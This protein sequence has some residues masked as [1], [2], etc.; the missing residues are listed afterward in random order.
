MT[1][2]LYLTVVISVITVVSVST[3]IFSYRVKRDEY[4]SVLK[5][6]ISVEK[7]KESEKRIQDFFLEY[8]IGQEDPITEVAKVLNVLQGESEEGLGEQAYI[9]SHED[10]KTKVV[11]F[12]SE[13]TEKEKRFAFAHEIAHLL[14]GDEIPA[15]RPIGRNKPE[16]EQVADYTAAA[17]LMPLEAVYS[18]LNEKQYF[19]LS[20]RKK[21]KVVRELCK[22]YQVSEVIAI[23]RIREV[24]EIKKA[25][26]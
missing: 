6:D 12:K 15:T 23:R 21:A 2:E 24:N 19:Q 9:R 7:M 17:L 10:G 16:V 11:V 18:S 14:N 13:L 5:L 1:V 26:R 22:K 4:K 25:V 8:G 3:A 20:A